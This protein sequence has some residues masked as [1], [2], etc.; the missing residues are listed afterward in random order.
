MSGGG[1]DG[2]SWREAERQVG[3]QAKPARSMCRQCRSFRGRHQG[4]RRALG[5]LGSSRRFAAS[6]PRR[7]C[8]GGGWEDLCKP[9]AAPR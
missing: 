8:D 2:H 3:S 9:S 6:S 7:L 1:G 5:R 4:E